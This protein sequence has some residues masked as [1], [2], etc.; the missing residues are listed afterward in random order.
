MTEPNRLPLEWSEPDP[1]AEPSP[2]AGSSGHSSAASPAGS[3]G[4]S[5]AEASHPASTEAEAAAPAS[6]VPA[7]PSWEPLTPLERRILGVLVEKQKTLSYAYPL[8]L[9]SLVLGC[10]QKDNRDPVMHV[11]EEEVEATLEELI[12]KDLVEAVQGGRVTHYRHK[13]YEKW[14]PDGKELAVLA[15]LLLRGAQS[16]GLLRA[17]ASRMDRI[18]N[19]EE[20]DGILQ[21]LAQRRLVVFLTPPQRRGAVV[22][23]GFHTPEELARLSQTVAAEEAD[24]EGG[25]PDRT[26]P[27]PAASELAST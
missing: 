23:H 20:L 21:R 10:N 7:P 15:E 5:A 19:A 1:T 8:S 17:R 6:T 2:S 3:E 12:R 11:T 9:N 22:T 25:P 27:S 4:Q 14:T 16:R 24:Q 18:S 26:V 13:L